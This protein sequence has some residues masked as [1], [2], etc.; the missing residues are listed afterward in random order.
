MMNQQQNGGL[1]GI[2]IHRAI[3]WGIVNYVN[4]FSAG[5]QVFRDPGDFGEL[6]EL[7][8]KSLKYFPNSFSY[9]LIEEKDLNQI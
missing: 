9:T 4:R 7:C 2:N 3:K 8:E 1:F 5:C 6:I